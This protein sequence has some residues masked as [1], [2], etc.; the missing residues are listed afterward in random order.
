MVGSWQWS[1]CL[2]PVLLLVLVGVLGEVV[3][4]IWGVVG[5]CRVKVWGRL[6]ILLVWCIKGC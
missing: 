4:I 2:F 3:G 5:C 6:G 1:G